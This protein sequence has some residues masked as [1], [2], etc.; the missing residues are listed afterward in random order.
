MTTNLKL[1]A[2]GNNIGVS[3]VVANAVG[4]DG[5]IID[6]GTPIASSL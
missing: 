3:V 2:T 4:A 1:S 5:D 6:Y